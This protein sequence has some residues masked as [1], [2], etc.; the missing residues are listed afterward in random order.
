MTMSKESMYGWILVTAGFAFEI[1]AKALGIDGDIET[2]CKG[3]ITAGLA[4]VSVKGI[5]VNLGG[6]DG[7]P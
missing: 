7:G 1:V 3:L 2:A 5:S 4:I 6:K